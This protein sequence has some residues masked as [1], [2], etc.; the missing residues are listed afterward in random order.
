MQCDCQGY[1]YESAMK[2]IQEAT[3]D[4]AACLQ[5]DE[6]RKPCDHCETTIE[7]YRR[8]VLLYG[9]YMDGGDECRGF[10]CV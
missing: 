5:E 2:G 10:V 4:S 8:K 9:F 7:I 3:D 6:N 1:G